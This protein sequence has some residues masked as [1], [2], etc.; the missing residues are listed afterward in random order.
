LTSISIKYKSKTHSTSGGENLQ[1]IKG[2]EEMK[3]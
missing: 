1:H 2:A 3:G